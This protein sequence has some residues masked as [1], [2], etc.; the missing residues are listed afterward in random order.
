M[1]L[2]PEFYTTSILYF[3][4]ITPRHPWWPIF[5]LGGLSILL[6]DFLCLVFFAKSKNSKRWKKIA[7]LPPLGVISLLF[8]QSS[9]PLEGLLLC[10]FMVN[11]VLPLVVS[12][13]FSVWRCHCLKTVTQWRTFRTFGNCISSFYKQS[14]VRLGVNISFRL[15]WGSTTEQ[16]FWIICLIL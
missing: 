13:Y 10:L 11:N 7:F 9:F 15:I 16:A 3:H 8:L 6:F 1:L 4:L 12:N 2:I 14:C 5:T